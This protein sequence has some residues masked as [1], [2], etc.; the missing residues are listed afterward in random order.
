MPSAHPLPYTVALVDLDGTITDSA[1][2]ITH[3]L[4]SALTTMGV[5]VPP[6]AEMLRF[7]GPP[8]LDGL[9]EIAGLDGPRALRALALYRAEYAS[10]GAFDSSVYPGIVDALRAIAATGLPIAIAT[11]KPETMARRILEHFGL[12]DLFTVIAG[13]SDDETRSEKADVITW[14]LEQLRGLDVDVSK[15]IMIGDRVH[16]VQGAAQHGIPTILAGWGY[17]APEEAAG[18]IAIAADPSELPGLVLPATAAKVSA[19]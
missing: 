7:V 18:T 6:P 12:L 5:A 10:T 11:S 19:S 17:G 1:P 9:R 15:P 8:I 4:A 14:A 3:T 2:G 16:D 13:A